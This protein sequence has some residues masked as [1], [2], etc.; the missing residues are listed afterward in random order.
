MSATLST[1]YTL[2]EYK[3]RLYTLMVYT[4]AQTVSL[5]RGREVAVAE[6]IT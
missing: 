5:E 3:V 2:D 4:N 1:K 6:R